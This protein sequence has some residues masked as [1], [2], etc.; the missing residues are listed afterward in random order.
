MQVLICQHLHVDI[1]SCLDVQTLTLDISRLLFDNWTTFDDL[2]Q[3][4]HLLGHSYSSYSVEY[5]GNLLI[6]QINIFFQ[7]QIRSGHSIC[8]SRIPRFKIRLRRQ[9]LLPPCTNNVQLGHL[10]FGGL[11]KVTY[12]ISREVPISSYRILLLL[13]APPSPSITWFRRSD[14]VLDLFIFSLSL[15]FSRKHLPLATDYC[16]SICSVCFPQPYCH[17]QPIPYTRLIASRLGDLITKLT[18]CS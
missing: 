16:F 13:S 1:D 2:T 3:Q 4:I 8:N 7:K 14:Y 12:V 5:G 18:A 11:R 17:A 9:P 15:F 10:V 6:Q